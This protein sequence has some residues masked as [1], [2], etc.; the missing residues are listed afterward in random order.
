LVYYYWITIIIII[1]STLSSLK[2]SADSRPRKMKKG[3]TQGI[4]TPPTTWCSVCVR[5][6][7]R[8]C[9]KKGGGKES[10]RRCYKSIN[11]R[12][13]TTAKMASKNSTHSLSSRTQNLYIVCPEICTRDSAARIISACALLLLLIYYIYIYIYIVHSSEHTWK[14]L[15][16]CGDG[17]SSDASRS[18]RRKTGECVGDT[19]IQAARLGAV[20]RAVCG[21]LRCP[22]PAPHCLPAEPALWGRGAC[23][24]TSV[25]AAPSHFSYGTCTP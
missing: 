19:E 22:G 13:K 3:G 1:V 15:P 9:I 14:H 18:L 17:D 20:G 2:E 25:P 7:V 12:V 24:C 16:D 8:A 6:R 21:L 5:A 23:R 11:K 10:A 4:C